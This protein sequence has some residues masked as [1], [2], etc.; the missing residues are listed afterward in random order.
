[1][2]RTWAAAAVDSFTGTEA[3]HAWETNWPV[4]SRRPVVKVV[5]DRA[6]GEVRILG[7]WKGETFAKTLLVERDLAVTLEEAQSFI[8]QRTSQ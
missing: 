2:R 7:R 1:L 3:L 4:Q 8:K 6:A 5:F